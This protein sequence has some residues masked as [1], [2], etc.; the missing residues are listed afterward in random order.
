MQYKCIIKTSNY[1]EKKKKEIPCP[2]KANLTVECRT[3]ILTV[4]LT[5]FLLTC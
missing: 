2:V 5:L 1:T 4:L 3:H